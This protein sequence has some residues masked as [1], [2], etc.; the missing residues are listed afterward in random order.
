[1]LWPAER[2]R[3]WNDD[4]RVRTIIVMIIMLATTEILNKDAANTK[5][6]GETTLAT[7]VDATRLSWTFLRLCSARSA[8]RIFFSPY[9]LHR[10]SLPVA[11]EVH[12][13]DV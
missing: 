11:R 8:W 13:S 7:I 1:M 6:T 9:I 4:N 12:L 10:L 5:A 2:A 3:H